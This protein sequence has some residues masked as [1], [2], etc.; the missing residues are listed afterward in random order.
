MLKKVKKT[1]EKY[2]MLSNGDRVVVGVSG[3]PDS[4]ALF[5]LLWTLRDEYSLSLLI[6]H[7]NHQFRGQSAKKDA[8]FVKNMAEN[9]GVSCTVKTMDVRAM[10]RSL[11]MT[12]EEAGRKARYDMYEEV[13]YQE[14][15]DR[16][17]VGHHKDDQAETVLL[18]LI[19]GAGMEGLGGMDPVR[20]N[21]IIRPLLLVSKKE[22]VD[23]CEIHGLE[24][25]IDETNLQTDYHRNKIRLELI[26][27]L[28]K[29]YNPKICDAMSRTA[30]IMQEENN[31]LH[32]LTKQKCEDMIE[33]EEGAQLICLN[34]LTKEGKALQRRI[35]REAVRLYKGDVYHVRFQHIEETLQIALEGK[36]GQQKT[37]P[38][39]IVAVK[40]Y[41]KLRLHRKEAIVKEEVCP[42][43]LNVPGKTSVPWCEWLFLTK[44][45][46]DM[47]TA[48]KNEGEKNV[49]LAADKVEFPLW[50][51]T[52]QEGDRIALPQGKGRKKVKDVFIDRKVPKR[53]RRKIPLVVDSAGRVVWIPEY[54]SCGDCRPDE[55]TTGWL[56]VK[57]E[58][59]E[60][61]RN[62]DA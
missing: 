48:P 29:E 3:G 8:D 49:L 23:Y 17:A 18:N 56:W 52:Q 30:K 21:K 57:M 16:I 14:R 60:T 55:E 50:V 43:K 19:R 36:P 40:E 39:G 6:A 59:R 9:F 25:R 34:L 2:Q 42:V 27:L 41:D 38:G 44:A 32:E 54:R 1:I 28:E 45:G 26:P 61:G 12:E 51:R 47:D 24:S 33:W 46:K 22:I 58:K 11:K 7:L 13:A 53:M 62:H 5:H 10:S 20:N 15:A 35:L 4:V 37:L 31:F